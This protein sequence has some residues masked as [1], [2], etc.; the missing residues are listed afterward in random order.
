M[1]EMICREAHTQTGA[2]FEVAAA[3]P[4]VSTAKLGHN[5]LRYLWRVPPSIPVG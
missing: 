2:T 3:R 1:A 4:K 5:Q